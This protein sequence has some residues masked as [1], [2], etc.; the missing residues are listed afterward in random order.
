MPRSSQ[1][2][3]QPGHHR[4]QGWIDICEENGIARSMPKKGCS[5]DDSACE[6][7]FGRVKNV[8][9]YYRDWHG[10]KAEELVARLDAFLRYYNEERIKESLGW[11]SPVQYRE[12]LG[13][14]GIV[15]WT[16]S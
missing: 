12:S 8:F 7:L 10:V 15:F 14:E 16:P 6:G 13:G 3:I 1:M 11:M 5:P 4:W 9:F 2:P